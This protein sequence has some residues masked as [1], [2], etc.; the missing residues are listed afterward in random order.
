[1]ARR[2]I[3]V[4][5]VDGRVKELDSFGNKATKP[6]EQNPGEPKY[7]SP[8]E[9]ITDISGVRVI[10]PF[11]NALPAVDALISEEFVV[12]ER[13][14]KSEALL[15]EEKFGY[16]SVHYLVKLPDTRTCLSEYHP[17]RGLIAE[18]QVRTALQHAWAEIEH[19]IQYKSSTVI[20]TDIRRRFIA[21]AGMLELADREFQ[22]IQNAD[23][24][25]RKQAKI[26]IEEGDLSTVE[27]TPD[28]VKQFL[29]KR[30]GTDKRVIWQSYD[31]AARLLRNL[32]FTNLSQ[33]E[34]CITEYDDDKLSRIMFGTRR[35]PVFRLEAS[36][37]AGMGTY[38]IERHLYGG[39]QWLPKR[40]TEALADFAR[41]GVQC[42]DYR[43][44]QAT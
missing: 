16:N 42:G 18:I 1:L 5:S 8:L 38:Y 39:S 10:A 37:L 28:A 22:E 40:F 21:L 15:A 6:A 12:V 25:I 26:D 27:I 34:A 24:K 19:D 33:V 14:D 32:G 3:K 17:F 23:Q 41:A 30:F 29:S 31:Y 35:G 4:L 44:D 20:P 43:P 2:G 11:P 13:S 7:P 9:D 36:L